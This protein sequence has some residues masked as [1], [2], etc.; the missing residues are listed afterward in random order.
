M[1][2]LE[3]EVFKDGVGVGV[4]RARECAHFAVDDLFDCR[5][6]LFGGRDLECAA[7]VSHAGLLAQRDEFPIARRRT[8]SMTHTSASGPAK[9]DRALVG[10]RPN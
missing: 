3:V 9:C 4:D 6:E 2:R 8:S 7:R 5:D 10:P 1:E